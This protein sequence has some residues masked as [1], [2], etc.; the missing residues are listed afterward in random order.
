MN[1][2]QTDSGKLLQNRRSGR[3]HKSG[4]AGQIRALSQPESEK[5]NPDEGRAHFDN[6]TFDCGYHN[7]SL[8]KPFRGLKEAS[9][10]HKLVLGSLAA[11]LASWLFFALLLLRSKI[12]APPNR[13]ALQPENADSAAQRKGFLWLS[14]LLPALVWGASLPVQAPF[15]SGQ[16]WG[17]GFLLGGGI[18]FLS[19]WVASHALAH[20]TLTSRAAAR[21]SANALGAC[22]ALVAVTIPLL[23]MRSAVIEA[24]LG[25]ALGWVTVSLVWLVGMSRPER[26][27]QAE[28]SA[29]PSGAQTIFLLNSSG[30]AVTLFTAAALGVYRDFVA[31][32]VARGTYSAV[33]VS[34]AA[35]V[36]LVLLVSALV[37]AIVPRRDTAAP[38]P[39]NAVAGTS[40][41]AGWFAPALGILAPLGSA[42]LLSSR[43]L[44][45]LTPFY[46]VAIGVVLGG[47]SWILAR[48]ATAQNA[49]AQNAVAQ[50][51]TSQNAVARVP[52]TAIIV[53]LCAF[54]LAFQMMQG[55]GVGLMLLG[56]WP[57]S[58]LAL[59][60]S[61]PA[62]T[63]D[64]LISR[65]GQVIEV[66]QTLSLLGVFGAMLLLSR[67]FA[68]RF[69]ADLRGAALDDPFALFGFLAGAVL[70]WLLTSL[71]FESRSDASRS[72]WRGSASPSLARLMGL[73]L[74]ALLFLGAMIV[75]WGVKIVPVFLIGLALS[76]VVGEASGLEQKA[77]AAL[78]GLWLAL[79]PAQWAQRFLPL[80]EW[81]RVERLHFLLWGMAGAAALILVMDYGSRL[82]AWMR[83]RRAA[84]AGVAL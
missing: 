9:M 43:F 42:Y 51:A 33:A 80:S 84:D 61:D 23:W 26:A 12:A 19:I 18:A 14:L 79:V 54:M 45:D 39:T 76:V 52:L 11:G 49:V 37:G 83:R 77:V 36:V 68:T 82:R 21:R 71:W 2:F 35:T 16:G 13:D 40:A 31:A 47:L 58:L 53:A 81:S 56:A 32:D 78:S 48:D 62:Q 41:I 69:R 73:G 46:A 64:A 17:R 27:A 44:D 59:T 22:G 4:G 75:L 70:P 6:F 34:L 57:I 65:S 67:L 50:N 8:G 3:R 20:R 55:F 74:L 72:L 28:T 10:E 29:S 30:F 38:A 1:T 63:N 7:I 5:D 24:L 60:H 25:G 15:S 66:A